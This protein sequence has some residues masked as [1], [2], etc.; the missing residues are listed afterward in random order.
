MRRFVDLFIAVTDDYAKGPIVRI[1]PG[2]MHC[3]DAAFS[4]EIFAAG[5]RRRDKPHHQIKA[6]GGWSANVF[7]CE[8]HDTHRLRRAPVAR[9]F[10]RGM[11]SGLEEKISRSS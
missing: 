1:N 2:E 11:L 3:S 9:F 8:D 10:S 4:D 5:G 7:G 6:L